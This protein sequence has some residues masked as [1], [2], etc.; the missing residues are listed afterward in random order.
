MTARTIVALAAALLACAPATGATSRSPLSGRYDHSAD[1]VVVPQMARITGVAVTQRFAFITSDVA[2][3]T[4]DRL[5]GSW[6]PPVGEP[7]PSPVR[8]ILGVA[9]HPLDDAAWIIE[10]GAV[11]RF[12]PTLGWSM[13][14]TI[15]GSIEA[16]V[17][18]RRDPRA[19]VFIRSL[20]G[21]S[22][23]SPSGIAMPVGADALPPPAERFVP[24]SLEELMRE[25]PALRG[26]ARLLTRDAAMRSWEPSAGA[27]IPEG[28]E[29]WL[30]TWGYGVFR[31]DPDFLRAVHEPYGLLDQGAGALALSAD[32]IWIAGTSEG[33]FDRN[34]ANALVFASPDL[35]DWL[36][37]SPAVVGSTA[38]SDARALV[39]R[40]RRA[41][42][43]SSR[44]AVRM[45]LDGLGS[46]QHL[47]MGHGLPSSEVHALAARLDGVW[48]GTS[49][50]LVFVPE[51]W[52]EASGAATP[53]AESP[54]LLT[55]TPVRALLPIGDTLW[56][57]TDAGLLVM[58]GRSGTPSRIAS[59]ASDARL[60]RP[61]L[62]LAHH[63]S[64]VAVMTSD[65]VL[66]LHARTGA[67][68]VTPAGVS[69]RT[70]GA[71]RVVRM[72]A[73]T[74]WLGGTRGVLVV[75]RSIG[76]S[77]RL[78]APRELPGE[79]RDIALTELF[80]WVAT[81]DGL[82]RLRRASDGSIR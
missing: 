35:R 21:W 41:W 13:R 45:D 67:L 8:R 36:W 4:F 10:Q 58:D 50:G 72:D 24:R 34:G 59:A 37:R 27:E 3:A 69:A 7:D 64:V 15:V 46:A 42:L 56:I 5:L 68:M 31:V 53:R 82:V 19:G 73:R 60:S 78:T 71:P 54:A 44:G 62:G 76:T 57:G 18:D 25:R 63:D 38:L 22:R 23:V 33:G 20:G 47:S 79:V 29:V 11:V 65:D 61:V 12:E 77:R 32:G 40:G 66:L 48:I 6:L 49:R 75:D 9:A 51:R 74:L 43:G 16:I 28:G 80:A 52:D 17:F 1:R 70:V 55:G 30:G 2:V 81:T 26:Y 14:T 39:V